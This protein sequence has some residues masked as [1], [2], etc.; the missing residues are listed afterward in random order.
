ML[1]LQN[2][3]IDSRLRKGVFHVSAIQGDSWA[4]I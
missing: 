3:G 1:A 2:S 4:L